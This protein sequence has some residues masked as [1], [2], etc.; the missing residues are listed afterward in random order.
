MNEL[1]DQGVLVQRKIKSFENG[2]C[3]GVLYLFQGNRGESVGY[4]RVLQTVCRKGI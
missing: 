3:G 1:K 2:W 4:T